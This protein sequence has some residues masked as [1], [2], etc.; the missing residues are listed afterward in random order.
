MEF[1]NRISNDSL[2]INM[3]AT[4]GNI[5]NE[6]IERLRKI[7]QAWNFYEGYHWEE[8]ATV[9]KPRITENYC[10]AFVNKFVSFEFGKGF[11]T[12]YSD[13]LNDVPINED[14]ETILEFVNKVG[15]YNK[16]EEFCVE[17]GQSKSITG[18]AWVQIKYYKP[19]ELDDPY[20]EHPKG[21]IKV[22]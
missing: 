17:L 11:T 21:M 3:I 18:D 12:K 6:D 1:K 7:K 2:N 8:I 16:F 22:A 10:R 5:S 19:D 20:G 13:I 9:D 4:E 14:G 15:N